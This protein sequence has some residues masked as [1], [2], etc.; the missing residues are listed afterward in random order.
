MSLLGRLTSWIGAHALEAIGALVLAAGIAYASVAIDDA[1][2]PVPRTPAPDTVE[3]E[4][5]ITKRDT[6]TQTV[7]ET[8]VR[9]D[10]VRVLDT[11]EVGVPEGFRYMGIIER[12][13][14]DI[15]PEQATLTYFR[16]G[17]YV[18]QR[19]DIPRDPWA[20][21]PE[22]EIR[23]DPWGLSASVRGALRWRDWTLTAGHTFA[24]KRSGW[25][26]GVRWRP[27]ELTW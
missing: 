11:I 13:P 20:L 19:Y 14:V 25:T 8:V 22:T 2:E 27:F 17:R 4:R 26:V 3:V 18:Q 6:V 9:Y 12:H 10:T 21:W 23:T 24:R 16:G 5:T 7:P 1:L 15:T